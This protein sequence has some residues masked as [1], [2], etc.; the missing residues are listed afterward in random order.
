MHVVVTLPY[1]Q[2]RTHARQPI[3]IRCL[4]I[5]VTKAPPQHITDA[6]HA[7]VNTAT[8]VSGACSVPLVAHQALGQ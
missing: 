6:I 3:E 8:Q 7:A 1:V 2:N 5:F 4:A